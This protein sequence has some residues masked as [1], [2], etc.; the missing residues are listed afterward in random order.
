MWPE[1]DAETAVRNLPAGFPLVLVSA[2]VGPEDVRRDHDRQLRRARGRWCEHLMALGHRRI[3]IIKGAEGNYDAAERLRGY[4]AALRR[5]GWSW[6]RRSRPAGDFS[7]SAGF[8]A[9][10]DLLAGAGHPHGDLRRERLDGD[11]RA[12]RAARG[13]ASG[14]PTTSRWPASTTSRWPATSIRRCPRCTW[15]SARWEQRATLRLLDA[16]RDKAAHRAPRRD[17]FPPRWCSG[18]PA[19]PLFHPRGPPRR[20]PDPAKSYS[21]CEAHI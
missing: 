8:Q 13:R 16:V 9:T 5:R 14:C 6:T 17:S 2:P 18:D 3:A 19:V 1:M 7:E 12:E 15:T 21:P 20:T 11:R 10:A 4:R